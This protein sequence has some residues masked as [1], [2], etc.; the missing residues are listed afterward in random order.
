MI[1]E[2]TRGYSEQKR[3]YFKGLSSVIFNHL[4]RLEKDF[5]FK[6]LI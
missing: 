4:Q 3:C 1:P 6:H 2:L 5:D